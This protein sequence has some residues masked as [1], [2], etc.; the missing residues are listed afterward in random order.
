MIKNPNKQFDGSRN[1]ATLY[2]AFLP[3]WLRSNFTY[4]FILWCVCVT[5]N[6]SDNSYQWVTHSTN[7]TGNHWVVGLTLWSRI[8]LFGS[9]EKY[10]PGIDLAWARKDYGIFVTHTLPSDSRI[11]DI[12]QSPRWTF[13]LSYTNSHR[14]AA[15]VFLIAILV[16]SKF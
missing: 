5:S 7:I 10:I 4:L 9:M 12:S 2:F 6:L 11:F 16:S 15:D 8:F 1:C 13:S 14:N 3:L